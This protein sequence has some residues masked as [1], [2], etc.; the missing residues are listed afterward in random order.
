MNAIS[1]GDAAAKPGQYVRVVGLRMMWR[2]RK[3]KT[4]T[5]F[6][7]MTL[8][9]LD[10]Y[11]DVLISDDVH[12]RH[13]IEIFQD[14]PLLIEGFVETDKMSGVPYIRANKI[15]AIISN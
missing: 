5:P 10:G 7:F 8:E 6:Y 15:K 1:T 9:D 13:H 11:I 2:S 14:Y 4:G 3:L 12:K